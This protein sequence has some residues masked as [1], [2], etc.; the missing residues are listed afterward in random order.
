MAFQSKNLHYE[1]NEP[2][3]LKRLKGQYGDERRDHQVSRPKN[4]RLATSGDDD[5]PTIVDE[6]GQSITQ[7]EYQAMVRGPT[8]AQEDPASQAAIQ[9]EAPRSDNGIPHSDGVS[10]ELHVDSNDRKPQ[11]IIQS[12]PG[13]KKRKQG[14]IIGT[15]DQD[16]VEEGKVQAK[17]TGSKPK[18]RPRNAK[19]VKL[20]FEEEDG[21]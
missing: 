4:P 16:V 9:K 12:G 10:G 2:T 1:K 11:A 13:Q 8:E 20:S 21:K 17:G 7:D 3:F 5:G 19:K 15:D 18:N 14:K 6:T